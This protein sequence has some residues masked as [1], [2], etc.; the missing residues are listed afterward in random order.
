MSSFGTLCGSLA[1]RFSRMLVVLIEF[2]VLKAGRFAC[3]LLRVE[4]TAQGFDGHP[5][6]RSADIATCSD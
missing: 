1:N 3:N 2:L 6:M 4:D 5:Y